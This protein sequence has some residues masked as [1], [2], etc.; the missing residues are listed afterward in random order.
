MG[1]IRIIASSPDAWGFELRV[2]QD[3]LGDTAAVLAQ[4]SLEHHINWL[5]NMMA[6]KGSR[7]N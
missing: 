2:L 6:L 3:H 1:F 4:R 7:Q 5:A